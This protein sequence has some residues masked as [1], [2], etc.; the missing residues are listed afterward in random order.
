MAI[1]FLGLDTA[2]SGMHTNQKSL[3]VTGHNISNLSTQGYT[4]QQA[5]IQTAN[6][7]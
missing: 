6:T 1:T 4:R 7:R 2:V 3:E 5:M